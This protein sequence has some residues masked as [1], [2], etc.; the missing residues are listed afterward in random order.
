MPTG[1]LNLYSVRRVDSLTFRKLFSFWTSVGIGAAFLFKIARPWR[2]ERRSQVN[3]LR[4]Q[5]G[6]VTDCIQ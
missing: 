4:L 5:Q 3:R 1:V 6:N 2:C